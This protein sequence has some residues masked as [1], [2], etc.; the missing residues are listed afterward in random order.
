MTDT[1][2]K[3][4][5][6]AR[7][8][9]TVPLRWDEVYY[10]NCPMV[11]ANNIDQELGWCKTDFKRTG[12]DYSYF[13]SRRETDFYP[14]YMVRPRPH[15]A[16]PARRL[17]PRTRVADPARRLRAAR[18]GGLTSPEPGHRTP[19][20]LS[21]PPE[22]RPRARNPGQAAEQVSGKKPTPYSLGSTVGVV[23]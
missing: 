6:Q 9:S 2:E 21:G 12:V 10:T 13:R 8:F 7:T 17:A 18:P 11:S 5:E 14:H 15:H 16:P 23:L 19:T 20:A 22:P 4:R 3:T 1:E